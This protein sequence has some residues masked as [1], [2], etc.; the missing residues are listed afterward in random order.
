MLIVWRSCGWL[1]PVLAIGVAALPVLHTG[2]VLGTDN[3][4][5]ILLGD[6]VT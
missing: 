1:V 5:H 2:R 3:T 4:G 6:Q